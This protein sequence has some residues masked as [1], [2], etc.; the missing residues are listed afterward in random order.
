MTEPSAGSTDLDLTV[1]RLIDARPETCFRMITEPDLYA[2]WFG[3]PDSI[4]TVEEMEVT[5]G[6]RLLVRIELPAADVVVRIEGFYEVIEAPHLIVHTWRGVDEELVTSVRFEM[7]PRGTQ[8]MMRIRHQ[9]FVDPVEL[10]QH[11]TGWADL[12]EQI[13]D[14]AVTIG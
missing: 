6:G 12:L 10:E 2:Q 5:L 9:G 8:T 13:A 3:P 14:L 4:V 7:E 1:D 11:R